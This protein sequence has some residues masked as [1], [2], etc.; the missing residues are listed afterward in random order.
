MDI[1]K[2]MKKKKNGKKENYNKIEV[3]SMVKLEGERS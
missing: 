3:E 1:N 2:E